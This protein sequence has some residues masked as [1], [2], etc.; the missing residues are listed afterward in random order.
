MKKYKDLIIYIAIIVGV[1][2]FRIYI[3]TPVIVSGL[4]MNP[5]LKDGN[6]LILN[7]TDKNYSYGDIVVIKYKNE[8]LI[9]R[10]IGVPG[11]TVSYKDGL[12]YINGTQKDDN[13]ASITS[14]FDL[15]KLGY[16]KI[17]DNYYLVLGDNRTLSLDSRY[18]GLFKKD[19]ILGTIS[20]RIY[21]LDKIGSIK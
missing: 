6:I 2:L 21:P 3:A 11:D 4:S 16:D 9:K 14:D 7:K 5:T 15:S 17:P 1:I 10:V 8:E 13:Y 12:L 20:F 18:L 19:D